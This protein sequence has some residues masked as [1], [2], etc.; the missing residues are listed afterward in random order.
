[1][2]NQ[3]E[4]LPKSALK[5]LLE[6]IE[7]KNDRKL[8]EQFF[9]IYTQLHD[10]KLEKYHRSLPLAECF[11]DRWERAIK[12]GFGAGTSIYDSSII[13]GD[14]SVGENTWIG[15]NTI[16]D[17]SGGLKIGNNCSISAGVQIYSHD[18]VEW[19]VS[20][21]KEPY[22]Y[23]ATTIGNNCYIGPNAIIEKGISIGDGSIVGANSFIN[24]HVLSGQ[25]V[26]GSPAK[27]I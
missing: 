12:L 3:G 26:A 25:R 21:G 18:S 5:K 17:G 16:L 10:E 14:V 7:N 24:K 15:P 13:L 23:G 1:M 20:G 19:A 6:Q 27:P 8:L 9:C 2:N 4:S 22:Q 11:V